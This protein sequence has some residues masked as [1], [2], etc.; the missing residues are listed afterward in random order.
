MEFRIDCVDQHRMYVK[1]RSGW[2]LAQTSDGLRRGSL[3]TLDKLFEAAADG[4]FRS[5]AAKQRD[6][7]RLD[8]TLRNEAA[9]RAAQATKHLEPQLDSTSDEEAKQ[10]ERA[11]KSEPICWTEP[12]VPLLPFELEGEEMP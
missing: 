8:R 10:A 5:A 2:V 12:G 4:A 9:N 7:I 6:A 3:S 11:A 1:F